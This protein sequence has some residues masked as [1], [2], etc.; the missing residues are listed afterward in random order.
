M[1]SSHDR[2]D[3]TCALRYGRRRCGARFRRLRRHPRA[4]RAGAGNRW[5]ARPAVSRRLRALALRAVALGESAAMR[6][7]HRTVHRALW[8]VLALAVALGVTMALALRPP[9]EPPQ[10]SEAAKP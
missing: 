5:R 2:A 8:P 6:R 10:A 9:P 4:A 3:R 1:G 7:A